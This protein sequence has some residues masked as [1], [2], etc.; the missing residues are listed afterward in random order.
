MSKLPVLSGKKCIKLLEKKGFYFK[1]QE[2]SHIILRRDNPFAQVVVP[3]HKELDRGTLRAI[4]RQAS[5]SVDEFN[6][7]LK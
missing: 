5:L 3:D 2:G 6:Q 1:R 4:I 7:I